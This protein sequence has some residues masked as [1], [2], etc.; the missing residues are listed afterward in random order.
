M[1]TAN[2]TLALAWRLLASVIAFSV[3]ALGII[4]LAVIGGTKE[5]TAHDA[6]DVSLISGVVAFALLIGLASDRWR[7]TAPEQR[8][9]PHY[10]MTATAATVV[11]GGT[12]V[13]RLRRDH[14]MF[15]VHHCRDLRMSVPHSRCGLASGAGPLQAS[16]STIKWQRCGRICNDID[17]ATGSM[18]RIRRPDLG[19]RFAFR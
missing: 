17:G 1:Q 19:K 9:W 7:A 4:T 18:Y 5:I 14:R 8:R 2:A 10:L 11:L 12:A 3:V 6:R 15:D 13:L 16:L